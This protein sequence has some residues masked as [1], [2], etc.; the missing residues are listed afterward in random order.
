MITIV[1]CDVTSHQPNK[2][3]IY[4]NLHRQFVVIFV[5]LLKTSVP[6]PIWINYLQNKV[7]L[8]SNL[9]S[10]YPLERHEKNKV[11]FRFHKL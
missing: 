4:T 5:Y 6:K 2:P 9:L 1:S 11:Y 10:I 8:S 7:F 3:Y